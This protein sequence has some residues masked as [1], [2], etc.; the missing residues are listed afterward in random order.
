[1]LADGTGLYK[2]HTKYMFKRQ[3]NICLLT[4]EHFGNWA[5]NSKAAG[6]IPRWDSATAPFSKALDPRRFSKH[7][8]A[9]TV[10]LEQEHQ[11]AQAALDKRLP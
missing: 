9:R 6:L 2:K 4:L 7:P 10:G 5:S 1:M 8:A 11:A 3:E